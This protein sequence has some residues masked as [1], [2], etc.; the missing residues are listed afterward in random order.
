MTTVTAGAATVIMLYLAKTTGLKI[1]KTINRVLQLYIGDIGSVDVMK[2]Q[3]F[4]P[5]S[6][7]SGNLLM[8]ALH[9]GLQAV[10]GVE[11]F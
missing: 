1:A 4:T 7:S 11:Q 9:R 8:I 10:G 6:A 3:V 2:L 5:F